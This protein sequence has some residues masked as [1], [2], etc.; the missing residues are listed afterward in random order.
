[1]KIEETIIV[2]AGMAGLGCAKKLYENKHKFLIISEDVGGRVKT[3]PDGQVNYGAYYL[4]A[5]CKNILPF[6]TKTG[7]VQFSNSHLHNG[8]EHYHLFSLRALKHWPAFLRLLQ[9]LY[10]FK[11]HVNKNR[12]LAVEKSREELIESNPL[13]KKYYHQKAADYIKER[14]LEKIVDEY[15]EQFLWASFFYDCRKVSTILFLGSLLPLVTQGYSFKMNFN[16]ITKGFKNRMIT[17]SVTKVSRKGDY[18]ELKTKKGR[19]YKCK[20]LVL[21]TPMTITNKLV[22]P[23]KINGGVSVSYYHIKGE[24]KESYDVKGYNFFALKERTAI[25]K[26]K[27]GTYLYFYSGK[28]NIKKYFKKWKVIAH[29]SWKPALYF[30]GDNYVKE[31]PEKNLYIAT[32]HNAPSMEDAFINGMYTAK[33]VMDNSKK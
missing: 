33:L 29:D 24:I 18:F 15:I 3:S 13:L 25:S 10:I 11:E 30:L 23:Q 32:D 27:D 1:M 4:T 16:E 22:K 14:N 7:K 9:D 19:N 5:D 31:N 21:A 26:E 6:V 12:K 2:G 20:N 28:D 8:N 17:D